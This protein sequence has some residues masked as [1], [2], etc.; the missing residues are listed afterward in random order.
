MSNFTAIFANSTGIRLPKTPPEFPSNFIPIPEKYIIINTAGDYDSFKYDYFNVVTEMIIRNLGDIEIVQ[1]GDPKDVLIKHC[2]DYRGINIR[3]AAFVI[4]NSMML[5]SGDSA[6]LHIA[7]FKSIPFLAL[8]SVTPAASSLPYYKGSYEVIESHRNGKKPSYRADENPKTINLI[9][10]EEIANR[11]GALIG[12]K[13]EIETKRIGKVYGKSQIDYIPDGPVPNIPNGVSS[14]CRM[15]VFYNPKNLEGYLNVT[16]GNISTKHPIDKNILI[17]YK[18][19]INSII[20]ILDTNPSKSFINDVTKIGIPLH[21]VTFK[22]EDYLKKMKLEFF[23][24][25][26]ILHRKPVNKEGISK[27]DTFDTNRLYCG[28]GKVYPSLYHYKKDSVPTPPVVIGD[29]LDDVD[30]EECLEDLIIFK[31]E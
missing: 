25:G 18:D 28:R 1:L 7:G 5:I 14:A 17:R 20:Y 21:L 29:A 22:D 6:Y 9:K 23:E 4:E 24:Y 13:V 8:F 19:K 31:G 10:P 11:I 3:Q 16:S 2:V 27:A 26:R 30:F 15:D 12:F